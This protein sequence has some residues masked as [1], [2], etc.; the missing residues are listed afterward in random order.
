MY[1]ILNY[2]SVKGVVFSLR[3]PRFLVVVLELG[4]KGMQAEV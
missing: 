3:S 4:G 1:I 2:R